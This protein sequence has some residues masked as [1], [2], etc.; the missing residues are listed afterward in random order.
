M[1]SAA[2]S[3]LDLY[4][5]GVDDHRQCGV[6]AH[7]Q[8]DVEKQSRFA[9]LVSRG[10]EIC[11]EDPQESLRLLYEARSLYQ[12]EEIENLVGREQASEHCPGRV[13][14]VE[15]IVEFIDCREQSRLGFRPTI[16]RP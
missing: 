10:Q 1:T 3:R 15:M 12:E 9:E 6:R 16:R 11:K 2:L 13:G 8:V 14:D 7:R 5:G 4:P